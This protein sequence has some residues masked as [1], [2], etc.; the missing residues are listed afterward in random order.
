M[1]ARAHLVAALRFPRPVAIVSA[2]A[3]ALVIGHLALSSFHFRAFLHMAARARARHPCAIV[4][5]VVVVGAVC[6]DD[7]CGCDNGGCSRGDG[8]SRNA[9]GACALDGRRRYD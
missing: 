5:V 4:V 9:F 7:D 2:S 6:S 8:H 3:R 1:R